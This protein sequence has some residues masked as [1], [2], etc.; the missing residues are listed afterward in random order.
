MLWLVQ[1][2]LRCLG[3]RTV[4]AAAAAAVAAVG[5]QL[6]VLHL[7]LQAMIQSQRPQP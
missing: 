1:Q 3:V 7:L 6:L 2:L 5:W 4:A